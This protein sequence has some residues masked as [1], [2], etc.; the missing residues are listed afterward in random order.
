MLG[1]TAYPIL[2][3]SDYPSRVIFFV[4]YH[5]RFKLLISKS[6]VTSQAKISHRDPLCRQGQWNNHHE[7]GCYKL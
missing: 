5:I 1:L 2:G 7:W 6:T 4:L 3:P